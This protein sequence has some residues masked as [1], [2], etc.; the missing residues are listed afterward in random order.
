MNR[1]IRVI[2]YD[3]VHPVPELRTVRHDDEDAILGVRIVHVD[4]VLCRRED[5]CDFCERLVTE[6]VSHLRYPIS[7]YLSK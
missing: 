2:I 3:E 1:E 7:P 6:W 5:R 4:G